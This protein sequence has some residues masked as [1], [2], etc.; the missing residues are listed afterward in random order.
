MRKEKKDVVACRADSICTSVAFWREAAQAEATLERTVITSVRL[1]SK[2]QF[3]ESSEGPSHSPIFAVTA[4]IDGVVRGKGM[5]KTKKQAKENAA[6]VL[7]ELARTLASHRGLPLGY[8][9]DQSSGQ[10]DR[11]NSFSKEF[12]SNTC[13]HS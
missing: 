5:G 11:C 7:A 3:V 13:M 1:L 10:A 4:M 8:L 12:S 9:R 6:A 2:I